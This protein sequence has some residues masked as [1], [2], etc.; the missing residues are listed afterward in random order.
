[1]TPPPDITQVHPTRMSLRLTSLVDGS[2]VQ[3]LNGLTEM[4]F[5]CDSTGGH[6][7]C[8]T[9]SYAWLA[10]QFDASTM[11]TGAYPYTLAVRSYYPD[12][13]FNETDVN[14]H[15]LVENDSSSL[16]GAGWTIAGF[17]HLYFDGDSLVITEGN[18]SIGFFA[19]ASPG[20]SDTCSYT[21]PAG[22]FSSVTKH[23]ADALNA[24]YSRRYPDGT[25]YG[26]L[27]DGRLRY[28]SDAHQNTTRYDYDAW[29]QLN[30]IGDTG[31][32]KK[33][34]LGYSAGRLNLI[35]DP[36]SR[37]D[38]ITID[39][40]GNL[41]QIQDAVGGL[42]FQGTYDSNHRL[43]HWTDRR[44]GAWG[45]TYDFANKLATD[46][47]PSI[48]G[49][50]EQPTSRGAVRVVGS[51]AAG[52]QRLRDL[53]EPHSRPNWAQRP[54]EGDESQRVQHGLRRRS[55]PAGCGDRG[56]A[57]PHDYSQLRFARPP[58]VAQTALWASDKLH[59]DWSESDA[60]EGQHD[61]ANNQLH[62]RRELQSADADQWR[63]GFR[64]Q[65]VDERLQGH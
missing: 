47:A 22:N 62:L 44:G 49:G 14:I 41:T 52:G 34:S 51:R 36:G 53:D 29:N 64:H 26:F 55:L 39:A 46:T 43:V 57:R 5:S 45:I 28:V 23:F 54:R 25:T 42:P 8:S 27:G 20:C 3:F 12:S 58:H 10:A 35:Q 60:V 48:T 38:W 11:A 19:L 59:L 56:A 13:T 16:F 15:V 2:S 37:T 61:G 40:S 33:A 30:A 32:T 65:C 50:R 17:Q 63:R 1:V 7:Y 9:S 21:S 4:F 24:I 31:S 6:A 18:G